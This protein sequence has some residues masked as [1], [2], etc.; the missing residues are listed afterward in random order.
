MSLLK[1]YQGLQRS[2]QRLSD[3][4]SLYERDKSAQVLFYF[5][6][7]AWIHLKR[8]FN[9]WRALIFKKGSK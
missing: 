4:L 9:L 7:E 5:K 1:I 3:F 2:S 6:R 8:S